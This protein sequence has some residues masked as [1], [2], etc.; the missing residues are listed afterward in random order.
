MVSAQSVGSVVA[1]GVNYGH[2]RK[3]RQHISKTQPMTP[4]QT[5][6]CSL[7]EVTLDSNNIHVRAD[8]CTKTGRQPMHGPCTLGKSCKMCSK[9]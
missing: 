1:C 3:A 8:C 9:R 2:M 4:L 7:Q 5:T 6:A